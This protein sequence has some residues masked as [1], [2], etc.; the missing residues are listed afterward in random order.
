MAI[1]GEMTIYGATVNLR[2]QEKTAA[3]AQVRKPPFVVVSRAASFRQPFRLELAGRHIRIQHL[4]E[5][6]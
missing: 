4:L 2:A 3:S 6:I 1:Y 5:L